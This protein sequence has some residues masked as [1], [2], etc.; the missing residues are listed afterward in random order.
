MRA[1]VQ[2]SI[3]KGNAKIGPSSDKQTPNG[4]S[5]PVLKHI[6]ALVT[7]ERIEHCLGELALCRS[8]HHH[9]LHK[10]VPSNLAVEALLLKGRKRAIHLVLRNCA[11]PAKKPNAVSIHA[12]LGVRRRSRKRMGRGVERVRTAVFLLPF[13]NLLLGDVHTRTLVPH[14]AQPISLEKKKDSAAEKKTRD[15]KNKIESIKGAGSRHLRRPPSA[16]WAWT[17][18]TRQ[19]SLRRRLPCSAW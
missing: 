19:R 16:S 2:Q 3:R 12:K 18:R 6:P 10:R 14:I 9:H 7:V 1:E 13:P 4:R 8:F 17:W 11:N 15:E 5:S